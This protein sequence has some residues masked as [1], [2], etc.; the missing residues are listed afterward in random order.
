MAYQIITE[1]LTNCKRNKYFWS[2]PTSEFMN[3]YKSENSL[4]LSNLSFGGTRK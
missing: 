3:Y 1:K 4:L 2:K